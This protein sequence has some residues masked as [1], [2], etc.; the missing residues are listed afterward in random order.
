[1][2]L[3]HAL[4]QIE[5]DTDGEIVLAACRRFASVLT[6]RTWDRDSVLRTHIYREIT[7]V[8]TSTQEVAP[9]GLLETEKKI[10]VAADFLA[11]K[12][13]IAFDEE[14]QIPLFEESYKISAHLREQVRPDELPDWVLDSLKRRPLF[15]LPQNNTDDLIG[16]GASNDEE[17]VEPELHLEVLY[18]FDFEKVTEVSYVIDVDGDIEDYTVTCRYLYDNMHIDERSSGWG[19]DAVEYVDSVMDGEVTIT[20]S[21]AHATLS[22]EDAHLFEESFDSVM[23]AILNPDDHAEVEDEDEGDRAASEAEWQDEMDSHYRR[24]LGMIALNSQRFNGIRI[25]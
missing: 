7:R 23:Q 5:H 25:K 16:S 2:E 12:D 6:D 9:N 1:M 22:E 21:H 19:E 24:A 10:T 13:Q 15:T 18:S 14:A 11:E 3:E 4:P 20:G 8:I 17:A